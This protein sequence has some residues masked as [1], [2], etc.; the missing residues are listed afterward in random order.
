M[1]G[2]EETGM[3][4]P[5]T[6]AEHRLPKVNG[7]K[8]GTEMIRGK[9]PVERENMNPKLPSPRKRARSRK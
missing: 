4:Q 2:L 7:A 8:N 3:A 6:V 9:K 1:T 5:D